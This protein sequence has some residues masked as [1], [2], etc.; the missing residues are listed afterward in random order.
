MKKGDIL[1]CKKDFDVF[2]KNKKYRVLVV[3]NEKISVLVTL[4]NK[5]TLPLETIN[6][7]FKLINV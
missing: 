4:E 6:K 3:D 1:I 5:K 7:K 2:L